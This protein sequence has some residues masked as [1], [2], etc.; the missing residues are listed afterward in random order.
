MKL[1]PWL[2][3]SNVSTPL[4][5][6]NCASPECDGRRALLGLWWRDEGITAQGQWYCSAD[7]CRK[8]VLRSVSALLAAAKRPKPLPN[9]MPLGLLLVSQGRLREEQVRAALEAQR[10]SG[11]GMIGSWLRRAGAISPETLT[12]AL[13]Q[14]SNCPVL[15]LDRVVPLPDRVPYYLRRRQRVLPV[16]W[17]SARN[18]LWIAFASPVRHSV[19]HTIEQVLGCRCDP[20]MVDEDALDRALEA[21]G[22]RQALQHETVFQDVTAPDIA[23]IAIS[24]AAQLQ[25]RQV[26]WVECAGDIWMRF[27]A[28]DRTSDVFFEPVAPAKSGHS[29]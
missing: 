29:R 21:G 1:L 22:G 20:C 3:G 17:S 13:G 12:R 4:F 16:Y 26:R 15:A 24:Y 25:A 2:S 7:C 18:T 14:Q 5:L 28:G 11:E 10:Q 19:L 6:P 27:T 8:A 23:S 9:R